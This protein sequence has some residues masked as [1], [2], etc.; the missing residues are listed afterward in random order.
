MRSTRWLPLLTLLLSGGVA[1][2]QDL[3]PEAVARA[4]LVPAGW[5]IEAEANGDLDADGRLDL[6]LVLVGAGVDLSPE[7]K[8]LAG[9]RRL[10]IAFGAEGGFERVISNNHFIPPADDPDMEDV[11]DATSGGLRITDGNLVLDLRLFSFAGGWSMWRKS[12][13]FHWQDGDFALGLFDW[14]DVDRSSGELTITTA[15]YVA[16]TITTRHGSISSDVETTQTEPFSTAGHVILDDI[17]DG[18]AFEP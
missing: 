12:Y 11:F 10:V 15:D 18:L 9:P 5:Q 13:T 2:A 8:T 14:T 3:P 17:T 4:A 7:A 16:K 1:V 6:A